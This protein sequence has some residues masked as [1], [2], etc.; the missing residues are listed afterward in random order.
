MARMLVVVALLAVG[1]RGYH[2]DSL[3]VASTGELRTVGC[4]DMAVEPDADPEAVGPVVRLTFANRC[5][6]AVAVDLAAI[7]ASAVLHDGRRVAMRLF[8][9]DSVVR[10]GLLEARLVGREILEFQAP[11]DATA[12]AR[13]LCLD[14]AGVDRDAALDRPVIVCLGDRGPAAVA[15]LR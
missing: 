5:D 13:E 9:P 8:D 10:P 3:S 12:G 15:V 4:L 14:L 2:P 11:G 1:C 6:S 7:R